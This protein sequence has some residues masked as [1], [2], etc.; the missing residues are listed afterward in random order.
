MVIFDIN[1][2]SVGLWIRSSRETGGSDGAILEGCGDQKGDTV[3]R[4]LAG[5][6]VPLLRIGGGAAHRG[7][8][9]ANADGRDLLSRYLGMQLQGKTDG[10]LRMDL[11]GKELEARGRD[12]EWLTPPAELLKRDRLANGL[13]P[14]SAWT[15]KRFGR[16]GHAFLC[17][18]G[19]EDARPSGA[20]SS[21]SLPHRQLS[22]SC[23]AE[24]QGWGQRPTTGHGS[25][26][27][28]PTP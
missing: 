10:S 4:C 11:R 9:A 17:Q 20:R 16:P 5:L 23:D 15:V 22:D 14:E 21:A 26:P 7:A 13:V 25:W 28:D 8:I 3:I 12:A 6:R 24:G 1:W 27:G 18:L 2:R 19:G